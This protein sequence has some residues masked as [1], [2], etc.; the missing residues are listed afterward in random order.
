ML[1]AEGKEIKGV[2][3]RE[4]AWKQVQ[5]WQGLRRTV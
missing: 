1:R 5:K 4:R 3:K 2:G